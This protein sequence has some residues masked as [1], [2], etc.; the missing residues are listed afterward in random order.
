MENVSYTY[1]GRQNDSLEL[2]AENWRDKECRSN[3]DLK[4]NLEVFTWAGDHDYCQTFTMESPLPDRLGISSPER[5]LRMETVP[6]NFQ[7]DIPNIVEN[8]RN[9]PVYFKVVKSASKILLLEDSFQH[10]W[11]GSSSTD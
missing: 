11:H 10:S 7:Q 4:G 1:L 2:F 5:F 6:S 9:R 3:A 8:T